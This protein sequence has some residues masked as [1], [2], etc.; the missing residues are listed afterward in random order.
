MVVVVAVVLPCILYGSG[1][2]ES[3]DWSMSDV[4]FRWFLFGLEYGLFF[5]KNG[6]FIAIEGYNQFCACFCRKNFNYIESF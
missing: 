3:V 4:G 1:F 2:C 6:L 5:K